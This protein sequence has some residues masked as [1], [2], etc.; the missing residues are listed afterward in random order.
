MCKSLTIVVAILVWGACLIDRASAQQC[1]TYYI[2][3][4]RIGANWYALTYAVY[5]IARGPAVVRVAWG[6]NF[7]EYLDGASLKH[8]TKKGLP[9][10]IFPK[11]PRTL[12]VGCERSLCLLATHVTDVTQYRLHKWTG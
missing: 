7:I 11:M 6:G 8:L 1:R 12:T 9:P 3:M 10:G 4:G 2:D 5:D